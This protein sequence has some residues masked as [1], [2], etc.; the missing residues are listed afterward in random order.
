MCMV[1]CKLWDALVEARGRTE[2]CGEHSGG[3]LTESFGPNLSD[4][5]QRCHQGSINEQ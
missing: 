2:A 5:L 1:D 4:G 3:S